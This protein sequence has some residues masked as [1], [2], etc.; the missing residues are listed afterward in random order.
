MNDNNGRIYIRFLD[1]SDTDDMLD[2]MLRN[3]QLF[4]GVSPKRNESFYTKEVQE[5]SI[6]T[7]NS[8]R[9]EDKRYAFGIFLKETQ[10]LIGDIALFEVQRGPHQKCIL[11]YS[12]DQA[13]NGKGYMTEAIQLILKYAFEEVGLQRVE[14][15]VMPRNVGSIRVLEKAGFQQEGL[16]RKLLEINGKR[17][18]HLLFAMLAEDFLKA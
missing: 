7:S 4:E 1:V 13:H 12:M 5:K 14:A 3:R 10:Q 16:N 8:Q 2:L 9:E 17:E 18:D 15:G 6:L 11:G